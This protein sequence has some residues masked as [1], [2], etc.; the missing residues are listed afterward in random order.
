M[1]DGDAWEAVGRE[2]LQYELESNGGEL[3]T[4]FNMASGAISRGE[5]IDQQQ[6]DEL[7]HELRDARLVLRQ[8]AEATGN[9]PEREPGELLDDEDWREYTELLAN[10]AD[11]EQ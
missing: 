3:Y 4:S 1:S 10:A 5:S 7:Y 8:L 2:L 6:I 11:G 9:E